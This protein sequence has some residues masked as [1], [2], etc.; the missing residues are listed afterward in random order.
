MRG[1]YSVILL[2]SIIIASLLFQSKAADTVDDVDVFH[3]G[4][5][6]IEK[7]LAAGANVYLQATD[8]REMLVF[9]VSYN[10][11]PAQA[12]N[13]DRGLDTIL[14]IAKTT[15][16]DSIIN[17]MLKGRKIIWNNRDSQYYYFLSSGH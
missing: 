12:A 17:A 2:A 6:G 8:R 4:L 5:A 9:P 3:K 10:L 13:N 15:D 11:V 14:T 16:S 1:I 7:H